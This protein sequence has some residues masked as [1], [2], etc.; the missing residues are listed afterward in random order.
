M[1]GNVNDIWCPFN[2]DYVVNSSSSSHHAAPGILDYGVMAVGSVV[3]KMVIV[4]NCLNQH[5]NVTFKVIVEYNTCMYMYMYLHV[6]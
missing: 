2:N 3:E 1:K 5:V 4:K 6:H